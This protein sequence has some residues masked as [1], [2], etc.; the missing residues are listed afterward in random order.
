M[1]DS[2]LNRIIEIIRNLNEEGIVAVPT[3]NTASAP[4]KPGFSELS[5][6]G[7]PTAGISPKLGNMRRR[8][9]IIGLGKNSRNRWKINQ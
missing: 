5:S 4:G 7:G 2:T 3:N 6:S 1:K 9:K 8:K